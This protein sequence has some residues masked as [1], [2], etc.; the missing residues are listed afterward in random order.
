MIYDSA[1]LLAEFNR[2][3]GRP[4]SATGGVDAITDPSKY[5]RLTKS[6]NRVIAML[7]AVAPYSL[8]PTGAIPT[9]STVD[10]KVFTFGTDA[11]GYPIFP[12]GKTGIYEYLEDIPDSPWREGYDYLNEGN[13]IRIPNN[14]TWTGTLYW[15]GVMQ[16]PDISATSQPTLQPEASRELITIDAAR[17]FGKEAGRNPQVVA[18]MSEEWARAWP[19]WCLVYKTQFRNGGALGAW[20]G[21]QLAI[22]SQWG[23]GI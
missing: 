8:Y 13:Q 5:D 17:Q 15:R 6:Q 22:A 23:S 21:R 3:T 18:D 1:D 11:D 9:L 2:L 16:P 10:N 4:N 19:Q 12:M 7:S 20:S 14:Q